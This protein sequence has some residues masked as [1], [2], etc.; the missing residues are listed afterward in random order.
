LRNKVETGITQSGGT[1]HS[2]WIISYESLMIPLWDLLV[3]F[4]Y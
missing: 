1:K 2:E 3:V 4:L